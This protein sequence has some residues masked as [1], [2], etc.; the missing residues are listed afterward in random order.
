MTDWKPGINHM[1]FWVSNLARSIAFY[2]PIFDIIGWHRVGD[3][4]F[5]SGTVE[6]YFAEKPVEW[7]DA[8]GP[9]HICF[10]AVSRDIVD[11]VADLIARDQLIRGPQHMKYSEGYYTVDFRDPDGYVLEVAYTPNMVL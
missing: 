9:R 1:E 8:I 5:S 4:A 10:Q 11:R 7:K 2:T 6:I 3:R